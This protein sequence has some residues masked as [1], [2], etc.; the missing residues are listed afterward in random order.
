[1]MAA[2]A[3]PLNLLQKLDFSGSWFN[4]S[5]VISPKMVE[6]VDIMNRFYL[7]HQNPSNVLL[8]MISTPLGLIGAVGLLNYATKGGTASLVMFMFYALSLVRTVSVGAFVGT[9]V[10]C[11]AVGVSAKAMKPT[12]MQALCMLVGG[13]MLQDLAHLAT[14]EA[15]FQGTY[16]N[17]GSI[18]VTSLANLNIWFGMFM[19]HCYYLVPFNVDVFLKIF[20]APTCTDPAVAMNFCQVL[21]N[22]LPPH[23]Q[24]IYTFAYILTPLL[25]ISFGSYC[26]D[27]RNEFCF[28]PGAPFFQRM[29]QC[30]IITGD[31]DCRKDD[32][33]AIR[34]WVLEQFPPNN[35][36]SH[37]WFNKLEPVQHAAFDRI[38]KSSIIRDA[39]RSIFSEQ[40]YCFEVVEGMNEIYVSGPP[41]SDEGLNSDHV[42]YSRHVDGPLGFIPYVSVYRCIVGMDRNM[43]ITT[44]FPIAGLSHNACAGDVLCFDF[45]REIHYISQD[46]SKASISDEFRVVLKLHYCVY[47]RILAPLGWLMHSI[48]VRYNQAFRALF[49]KT[50]NPSTPYEHFLAWQ[51]VFTT[52]LF[53]FIETFFGQRS[54]FYL[55]LAGSLWYITGLYEVFFVMTSFVHYIRYITTFYLRRGIDFGSF[56]RDVLLFKTI[57]LIQLSVIYL[58]PAAFTGY[59]PLLGGDEINVEFSF[60]IISIALIVIGYSISIM[61]TNALGIDRT[62]FGAELGLMEPKWVTSFPYG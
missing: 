46:P 47:P 8:H 27:S 29:M 45:N 60:D 43:M 24:Q 16:S 19:E 5:V 61:A 35:T 7:V 25:C 59:N 28:F 58:Y 10:L 32:L 21:S 55:M 41:R 14:G 36:S 30:Q 3:L 40:N 9:L 13:Y 23:M 48:N 17:G 44:H 53:D 51:V 37:W 42:F 52:A 54:L 62:Y 33:S 34:K 49:L 4:Y 20:V 31:S 6:Y 12:P 26:V 50:I 11:F 22:P 1:M 39:F 57:A 56:K 15:T 18:D 2:C 38:A